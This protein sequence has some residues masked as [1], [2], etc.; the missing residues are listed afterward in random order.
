MKLIV[1]G[2]DTEQP[3]SDNSHE[4]WSQN[5][6]NSWNNMFSL[7]LIE[8]RILLAQCWDK[9]SQDHDVQYEYNQEQRKNTYG[10][11]LFPKILVYIAINECS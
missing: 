9:L 3:K 2:I 5:D 11:E 6:R 4:N 8:F 1:K 10:L 7:F